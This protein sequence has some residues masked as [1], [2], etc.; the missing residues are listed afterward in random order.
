MDKDHP[1]VG[2]QSPSVTLDG[3]TPRGIRQA[4]FSLVSGKEYTGRI[5]LRGTPGAKVTVSLVWGT[6]P[7]D[8]QTLSFSGLNGE[9]KKL[10]LRFTSKANSS[11]AALE[12]VGTGNG[13]FHIGT[14]SLMPADNVQGFRPDTIALLRDLHSG[15]WRLPGGNFLSDWFGTTQSA[16]STSALPCLITPGMQC[17]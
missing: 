11:D 12:I 10:P 16:T 7:E 5:Y 3:A 14:V 9:Y 4:G 13:S 2:D 17:R 1:F 15:M 6:G 8:K